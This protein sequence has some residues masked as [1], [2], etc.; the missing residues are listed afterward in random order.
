M[1][2]MRDVAA[3]LQKHWLTGS[4]WEELS[5]YGSFGS[6]FEPQELTDVDTFW[7]DFKEQERSAAAYQAGIWSPPPISLHGQNFQPHVF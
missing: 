7:N 6:F 3:G 5:V 4:P 1:L 2:Q